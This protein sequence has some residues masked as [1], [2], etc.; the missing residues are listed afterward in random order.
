MSKMAQI[1][2]RLELPEEAQKPRL[3]ALVAG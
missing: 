1:K 2:E 3:S